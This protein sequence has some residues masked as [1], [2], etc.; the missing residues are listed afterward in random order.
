MGDTHDPLIIT[1][2][3]LLPRQSVNGHETVWQNLTGVCDTFSNLKNDFC[4][5]TLIE[6]KPLALLF[7]LSFSHIS[8]KMI[9]K[10]IYF[11]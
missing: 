10:N 4:V 1:L 8:I 5:C 7:L 6:Y 2:V 11:K 3:L 9:K